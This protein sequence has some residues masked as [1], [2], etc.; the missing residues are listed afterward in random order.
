MAILSKVFGGRKTSYAFDF[1]SLVVDIHSHLIP[2]IDD[3]AQ[4]YEESLSLIKQLKEKGFQ[5]L[6]TTPHVMNDTYRNTP[7]IIKEGL[8]KLKI[9]LKEAQIEIE[10]EAAAEYLVDD[11]LYKIVESDD[12]LFFGDKYVLIELPFYNSPDNLKSIIFELQLSGYKIVLAHPERYAY[13]FNDFAQ[14]DDLKNRGVFFQL[15]IN[16]LSSFYSPAVKKIAE[17]LI[18]LKMIDFLGSDT[19]A[20]NYIDALEEASHE[21]IL[22]KALL[23][24]NLLNKTLI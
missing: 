4:S 17:K 5:K 14:Y 1:S 6:I 19:H 3:G 9:Q 24:C 7:V 21:K 22:S 23:N 8:E 13:W 2:C 18:N 16:S 10:I 15:N 11:G 12:I 20:R